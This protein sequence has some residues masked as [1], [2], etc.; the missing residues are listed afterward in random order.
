MLSCV[1]ACLGLVALGGGFIGLPAGATPA[2]FSDFAIYGKH[3]VELS[4]HDVT[5]GPIGSASDL[6][7]AT[8]DVESIYSAGSVVI[9]GEPAD[10][11]GDVVAMGTVEISHEH[12]IFGSVHSSAPTGTQVGAEVTGPAT[13][14]I[15]GD[16]VALGD[17]TLENVLSLNGSARSDG[18]L[19]VSLNGNIF[20]D[21]RA[22]G[23][24]YLGLNVDVGGDVVYGTTLTAEP[25]ASIGGS[26][27]QGATVVAPATFAAVNLP[28]PAIFSGGTGITGNGDAGTSLADPLLPGAY[29]TLEADAIYLTGGTYVFTA[30]E[31]TQRSNLYLDLSGDP[32]EIFVEGDVSFTSSSKSLQVWVSGDGVASVDFASADPNLAANL[33]LETHGTFR[34]DKRVEWFGAVYAPYEGIDGELLSVVGALYARGHVDGDP[35]EPGIKLLSTSS[36][37]SH[38]YVAPTYTNPIPEPGTAVLLAIGLLGVG[39]QRRCARPSIS[40]N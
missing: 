33:W 25:T 4:R 18:D 8:S 21:A 19:V 3:R 37:Q 28:A 17:V 24:I 6:L 35:A 23:S 31:L 22:N 7:A 13:A 1:R 16:V 15:T 36:P 5:G 20:G 38:V 2:S 30:I 10:V 26:A 40:P 12:N 9:D 11:D 27:S 32:I 14:I 39:L 29:G 34:T